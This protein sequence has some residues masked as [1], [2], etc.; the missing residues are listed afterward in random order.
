MSDVPGGRVVLV[1]AGICLL[2]ACTSG[3]S[4]PTVRGHGDVVGVQLRPVPEGP[5]S[6]WFASAGAV[7]DRNARPLSLIRRYLPSPLPAPIDQ[8]GCEEGGDLVVRFSDGSEVAYGPCVRPPAIEALRTRVLQ[9]VG[10]SGSGQATIAGTFRAIG[11]P[12][13]GIS[14]P[15]S[16]RVVVHIGTAQG[17]A[18]ASTR[19]THGRF[20]V[21]VPP[22]RYVLVGDYPSLPGPFCVS[23]PTSVRAGNTAR[24]H[25]IC[26]IP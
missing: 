16:G 6:P 17:R 11:G 20:R 3:S 14:Q 15:M 18:V 10:W 2:A 1:A 19:A 25:V 7:P 9:A 22:G 24:A 26:P 13:P 4:A 5:Y 21:A 8:G 23:Q 12:Y